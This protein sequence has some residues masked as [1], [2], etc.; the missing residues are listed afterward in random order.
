MTK[1]PNKLECA[2]CIRAFSHGGECRDNKFNDQGC[3]AF[4]LDP[5]GCIRQG[6]YRITMPLYHKFPQLRVW[7]KDWQVYGVDTEIRINEIYGID[8][9]T[10]EGRLIVSCRCD[11]FINEYHEDYKVEDSAP[12]L[13]LIK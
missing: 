5:R 11:Y 9:D 4:K 6:D 13:K 8:W 3:L 10:R 12:R 1:I 2:Y 7:N